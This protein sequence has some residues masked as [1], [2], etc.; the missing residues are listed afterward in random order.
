MQPLLWDLS[1]ERLGG[2]TDLLDHDGE[3]AQ[4]LE[5]SR[6]VHDAAP[7]Q[8]QGEGHGYHLP[9]GVGEPHH[10]GHQHQEGIGDAGGREGRGLMRGGAGNILGPF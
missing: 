4:H 8:H 3:G 1:I 7:A 9:A 2:G 5:S 6:K 10:H